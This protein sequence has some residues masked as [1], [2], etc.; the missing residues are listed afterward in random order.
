MD[1]ENT[2]LLSRSSGWLP[3]SVL[4]RGALVLIV[5]QLI[6]ALLTRLALLFQAKADAE[7]G[8]SLL[9]ASA[10]LGVRHHRPVNSLAFGGN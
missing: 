7:W 8:M 4:M 3:K 10:M 9:G 2:T 1:T 5:L 6:V